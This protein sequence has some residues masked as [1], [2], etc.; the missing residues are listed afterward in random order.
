[1]KRF[2]EAPL[3]YL[4][5]RSEAGRLIW[6]Q[7]VFATLALVVIVTAPFVLVG[8]ANFIHKDGFVDKIGSFSSVLTG[9][10]VAGL[11]AVATFPRQKNGLDAV[12]NF[13]K[14]KLSTNDGWEFLTRREYICSLFGYLS[15]ISLCLTVFSIISIIITSS[16]PNFSFVKFELLSYNVSIDRRFIRLIVMISVNI[17]ICHLAVSTFRGLYYL[18]DRMYAQSPIIKSKIDE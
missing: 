17:P 8:K 10:Y 18:V 1:M 14:I 15:T 2:L 5:L 6:L 4:R 11:V 3:R 7:D 12:I 16:L 9:F 13:G